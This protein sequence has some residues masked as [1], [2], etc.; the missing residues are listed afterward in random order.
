VLLFGRDYGRAL[1]RW[2]EEHTERVEVVVE[3]PLQR[4]RS[5]GLEVR[6]LR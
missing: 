5:L 3:V 6:R 2:V 4:P 1:Y